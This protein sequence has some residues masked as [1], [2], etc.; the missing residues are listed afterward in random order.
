MIASEP[1]TFQSIVLNFYVV[2][3]LV[4]YIQGLSVIHFFGKAKIWPNFSTILVMVVGTLLTPAT[5]IV[6]LLWVI[7]LC[8]NLKKIIKK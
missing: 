5:H 8:I 7:D 6:G 3:S 1:S 2:L 4:M